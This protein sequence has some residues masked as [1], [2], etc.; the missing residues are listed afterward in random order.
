MI[1]VNKS[2]D[3]KIAY[4]RPTIQM[5]H[6]LVKLL[7]N[8]KITNEIHMILATFCKFHFVI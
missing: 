2:K 4:C 6:L 5:F 8:L 3:Y 7:K 1:Y